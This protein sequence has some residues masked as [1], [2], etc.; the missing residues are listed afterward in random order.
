MDDEI[1][2]SPDAEE[3]LEDVEVDDPDTVPGLATDDEE[4]IEK[5]PL[6]ETEEYEADFDPMDDHDK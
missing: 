3:L 6:E 1:L 4:E 2:S 5:D